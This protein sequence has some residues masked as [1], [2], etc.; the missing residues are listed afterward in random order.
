MRSHHLLRVVS[1]VLLLPNAALAYDF[2]KFSLVNNLACYDFESAK[3][4]K[5]AELECGRFEEQN[6]KLLDDVLSFKQQVSLCEKAAVELKASN[7]T[8]LAA[9]N[10]AAKARDKNYSDKVVAES[11]DVLGGGWPWLAAALVVGVA[12]GMYIG[13]RL[14]K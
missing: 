1:L 4:L 14:A 2:P 8:L 11:R 12:S 10:A 6:L 13:Y 7:D 3:Q 9:F 5:L